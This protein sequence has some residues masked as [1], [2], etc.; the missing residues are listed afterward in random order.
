MSKSPKLKPLPRPLFS[1]GIFPQLH[2]VRAS[3]PTA[4]ALSPP[5]PPLLPLRPP[6]R[7]STSEPRPPRLLSSSSSSASSSTSPTSR[8]WRFPL[9]GIPNT[10]NEP[11]VAQVNVTQAAGSGSGDGDG[12]GSRFLRLAE[13]SVWIRVSAVRSAPCGEVA[14]LRVPDPGLLFAPGS[15]GGSCPGG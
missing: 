14:W 13:A 6:L 15:Y 7:A 5:P 10:H 12:G 8:Q 11:S 2:S 3:S 4:P 1:C 9:H